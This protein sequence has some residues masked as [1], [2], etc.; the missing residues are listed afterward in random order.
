MIRSTGVGVHLLARRPPNANDQDGNGGR[1]AK[2]DGDL[3]I[4]SIHPVISERNYG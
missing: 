2:Y 4:K 3:K 1:K